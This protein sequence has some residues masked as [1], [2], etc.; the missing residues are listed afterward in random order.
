MAFVPPRSFLS[1]RKALSAVTARVSISVSD[2]AVQAR[3]REKTPLRGRLRCQRRDHKQS[4][5]S[6]VGG[7]GV[8]SS[9]EVKREGS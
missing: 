1:G 8:T 9:A 4:D 7:G 5:S 3:Q 6:V 2:T